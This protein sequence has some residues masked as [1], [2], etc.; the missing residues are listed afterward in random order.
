MYMRSVSWFWIPVKAPP[1]SSPPQSTQKYTDTDELFIV[2]GLLEV[3]ILV[4]TFIEGKVL[5]SNLLLVSS[6][7]LM[8]AKAFVTD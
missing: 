8:Q 3:F 4:H 2:S 7:R 1:R 5:L 6:I